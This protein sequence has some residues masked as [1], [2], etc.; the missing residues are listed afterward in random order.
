MTKKTRIRIWIVVIIT[1]VMSFSDWSF[2]ADAWEPKMWT[3]AWLFN[4]AVSILSWIWAL[5]AKLAW[6]FFTNKRVY[7]E[8]LWLDALL[9]Q[10]WNLIKN[11]ANFLLW[12]YFIYII[13]RWLIKQG[14]EDIVKN[15]KNTILWI[16]IAWVGIQSSWFL[17]AV[18]VDVSTITLVAAGSLP[19]QLISQNPDIEKSVYGSMKEYFDE[20]SQNMIYSKVL[21]LFAT[22]SKSWEFVKYSIVPLD[23]SGDK[24]TF[25]DSL[26]PNADS[27]AWPLYYMWFSILKT[28]EINS[29]TTE[30][31]KIG[32]ALLNLVIQ[33]WTT[34]VYS[35]EMAV[36][37]V[38]ALM[39]ILYL[40]M[41]VVLSPIAVLLWCIQQSWEKNIMK[42]SFVE[43]LMEQINIKSFL[44]NVFKP[45][46]IVLWIGLAMIFTTLMNGVI[47]KTG[48]KS[49]DVNL[50]WVEVRTV[51][52]SDSNATESDNVFDSTIEGGLIKFTIKYVGKWLLDFI[53]SIITVIL[54]YMIIQIAVKMWWWKDFVSKNIDKLQDN[55][56]WAITSLPIVP[57]AW[58]DKDWVEKTSYLTWD[59][60]KSIP[61]KKVNFVQSGVDRYTSSQ[62]DEVMENLWLRDKNLLTNIQKTE[63]QQ[64]WSGK[65]G[66]A[67]LEAKRDYINGIKTE[68]WRK[69]VLNPDASDE[70]WIWEFTNWLN[71][72]KPT[73]VSDTDW[74]AMLSDWQSEP[75]KTK[76][77]LKE[78]FNNTKY[79][80][81]Y[82]NFFGYTS[83]TYSNFDSIKN[84]DISK[85]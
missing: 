1:C 4:F 42:I 26:V 56:K 43:K 55:V 6:E 45:T 15:I 25:F 62:V 59:W 12:F 60:L 48:D 7:W 54:V 57:V 70:F 38:L 73:E 51:A 85:K 18:V 66:L 50:W 3:V 84:L 72:T 32:K 76:R 31:G 29:I 9:W 44:I 17:T 27:I 80:T 65:S 40:W 81:K 64:A 21:N 10:Y 82:A 2:A 52:I 34:I 35:I 83:W 63:I 5:F 58:Y 16:L 68:G 46:V 77:D 28:N 61:E 74:S 41:F 53:M 8:V 71:G 78:L 30:N 23:G 79:A 20:W 67:V 11:I 36:L 69:M 24:K 19:A 47:V 49:S 13:F 75:D 39:R 22:D 33:W 37:C 14:K